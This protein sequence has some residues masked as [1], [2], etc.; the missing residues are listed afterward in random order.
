MSM[1]LTKREQMPSG[2]SHT[3][4]ENASYPEHQKTLEHSDSDRAAVIA[5]AVVGSLN[6]IISI[7][8]FVCGLFNNPKLRVLLLLWIVWTFVVVILNFIV[9][10]FYL[11]IAHSFLDGLRVFVIYGVGIMVQILCIWVV[12]SYHRYLAIMAHGPAQGYR[13]VFNSRGA[14]PQAVYQMPRQSGAS[15]DE[16]PSYSTVTRS[17][18]SMEL[19]SADDPAPRKVAL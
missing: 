8:L 17:T 13:I 9:I 4:M 6:I 7:A 10:V 1:K 16:P 11:I 3:M 14:E 5:I 19:T 2:T 12:A 18:T 15:A